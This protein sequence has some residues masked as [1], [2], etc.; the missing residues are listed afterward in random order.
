ME[1][2]MAAGWLKFL[3]VSL[4]AVIATAI[5]VYYLG[6][7]KGERIMIVNLIKMRLPCV[8]K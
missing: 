7:T 6:I 4:V 8:K 3:L 5:I 1:I 2:L